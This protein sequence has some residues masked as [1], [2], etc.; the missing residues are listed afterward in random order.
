MTRS[1]K[2]ARAY[3]TRIMALAAAMLAATTGIACA[4]EL[5]LSRADQIYG[6]NANPKPQISS[7]ALGPRPFPSFW[8]A[9][10][11]R[12]GRQSPAP[13]RSRQRD[14]V[15]RN[16]VKARFDPGA[17][18]CQRLADLAGGPAG[19]AGRKLRRRQSV[20]RLD[21]RPLAPE[22]REARSVTEKLRSE[23]RSS[24]RRLAYAPL[25]NRRFSCQSGRAPSVK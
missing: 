21:F 8:N 22:N 17:G 13:R 15:I 7:L 12:S 23:S 10:A 20:I 14:P 3:R 5:Y 19:L 11:P 25:R 24:C 9:R 6:A 1:K 2:A 18:L 4:Q 16:A